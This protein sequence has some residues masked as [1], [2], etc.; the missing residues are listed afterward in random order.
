MASSNEER[1]EKQDRLDRS[2]TSVDDKILWWLLRYPFQRV[3]DIML[4]LQV[5]TN[6]V[7]RHL[8]WMIGEGIVEYVTPSLGARTT[9]RLYYLSNTGLHMAATREQTD[10]R[11]LARAWD[12]NEQGLLRLLPRLSALVQLQKVINGLIPQAPAML[13][14][15][16]GQRAELAWH[17]QRDYLL[18][19]KVHDHPMNLSADAALLFYRKASSQ[20]SQ[21]TSHMDYYCALLYVDPGFTGSNDHLLIKR[22]LETLLR[23]RDCSERGFGSHQF[24]PV[25]V[26]VQTARQREI[27]QRSAAEV[28]ASL[29]VAPLTGA[30][31]SAAPQELIDTAWVLPWQKLAAATSCRL[32]DLFIPLPR[33]ALPPGVLQRGR[34]LE[35]EHPVQ[36]STQK[37]SLL[38]GNFSARAEAVSL[39]PRDNPDREREDV[40][41]LRLCLSQCH[42]DML[43]LLYT[44]PL[45]ETKDLAILLDLQKDSLTRYLYELRH[46]S[47]VEKHDA[48]LGT[49]WHLSARGLR[50]VAAMHHVALHHIAEECEVG[51][52]RVLVQRGLRVFKAQ[53]EQTAGI[54]TFFTLLVQSARAQESEQELLWWEIGERCEHRYLDHGSPRT[55]RPDGAFVYKIGPKQL[56]AWVEWEDGTQSKQALVTKMQAY[57]HFARTREWKAAGFQTLPVLLII[58]SEKAQYQHI[59]P[60]VAEQVSGSGLLVRLASAANIREHGPLAEIWLPVPSTFP[61]RQVAHLQR[62]SLLDLSL[63]S[64]PFQAARQSRV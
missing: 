31:I 29:Q 62:V 13:A 23:Y 15:E 32:R 6:T 39:T 37:T 19:F 59:A 25:L 28:A 22:R 55:L 24:P 21:G 27:W 38:R 56:L 20:I 57:A 8:T 2:L 9:C 30:I 46:Y 43:D 50:L 61:V 40:A 7:Y 14:H 16:K 52:A 18:R 48:D 60:I 1:R 36:P 58:L 53:L 5:S 12:A 34:S 63:H 4:A 35:E 49:H 10:A 17:W 44:H 3:E 41:L 26:L 51:S 11:S 64:A 33:Q 47:C 42:L 54:Y 45:L